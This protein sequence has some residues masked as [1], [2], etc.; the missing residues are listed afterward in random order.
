M[1]TCNCNV[2]FDSLIWAQK[3]LQDLENKYPK[4]RWGCGE[5]PTEYRRWANN[6]S[7]FVSFKLEFYPDESIEITFSTNSNQ[8]KEFMEEEMGPTHPVFFM[9]ISGIEIKRSW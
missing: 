7:D 5:K 9:G 2:L 3:F 6:F 1:M 8:I 4:A